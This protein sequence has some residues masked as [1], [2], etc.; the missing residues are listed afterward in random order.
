MEIACLDPLDGGFEQRR[1]KDVR[2]GQHWNSRR[3]KLP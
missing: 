3:A 2:E 1:L